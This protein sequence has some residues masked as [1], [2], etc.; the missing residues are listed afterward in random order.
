MGGESKAIIKTAI[1][2]FLCLAFF[3]LMN[4]FGQSIV[5]LRL[6]APNAT[7]IGT[8]LLGFLL[9]S[10]FVERAVEVFANV[11]REQEKKPLVAA[12]QR[13]ATI[14]EAARR[15]PEKAGAKAAATVAAAADD[16]KR[17]VTALQTYQAET[18]RKAALASVL[19]GGAIA[20]F[21]I[22]ALDVFV[23]EHVTL[24]TWQNF[25]FS[26]ADVLITAA[27]LGGGA[28]GIHKI[29]SVFTAY[30][31]KTKALVEGTAPPPQQ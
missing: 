8:A 11:W 18:R 1:A 28:D 19:L 25:L 24:G 20:L 2:G 3:W 15:G 12:V 27:L 4:R 7:D 30:A 29:I 21:G 9:V 14:L 5:P 23:A 26:S 22:R 6:S 13:S 17:A 16:H 31:D 10:L